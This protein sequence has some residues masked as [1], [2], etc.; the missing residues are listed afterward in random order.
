MVGKSHPFYL[1][2]WVKVILLERKRQFSIDIRSLIIKKVHY[3][4]SNEPKINVV[5]CP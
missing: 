5:R 4:L 2:F 3:E 1:K